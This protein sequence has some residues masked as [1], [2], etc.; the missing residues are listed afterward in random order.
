MSYQFSSHINTTAKYYNLPERD[1]FFAYLLAAGLDRADAY[2]IIYNRGHNNNRD[3]H[4]AT[5]AQAADYLNNSPGLKLLISKL[6]NSKRPNTNSTREEVKEAER[7]QRE[8]EE[9]LSERARKLNSRQGVSERIKSELDRVTGR[10]AIQGLMTL[11]KLEGYDK[12]DKR[13]DDERRSFYLPY[14]SRCRGCE[15]MKL[16]IQTSEE[17]QRKEGK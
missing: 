11:A 16:Y 13:P 2:Y 1:I 6:K 12:E 5:D 3:T 9:G 14:L 17:E 8:K 7:Q 10:D 15:L 4:T